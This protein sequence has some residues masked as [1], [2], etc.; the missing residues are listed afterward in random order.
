MNYLD[1]IILLPVAYG[2]I[3]GFMRG[4]VRELTS[5]IAV[6][7]G[8]IAA[9]IWAPVFAA[10]ILTVL[11]APEWLG[12]SLAY[13]LLF[14]GVALLCKVVARIVQRFLK[15]ISLGWLDKLVGGIFG[16][17]KWALI[18]SVLLNLLIIPEQYVKII[19]DD[20]KASSK[21]YGPTLSVA[22]TSWEKMQTYLPDFQKI[23]QEGEE[24]LQD[25][26]E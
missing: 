13:L 26:E 17:L 19:K 11:N 18:V 3:R 14:V 9:K 6:I 21:L 25:D 22:S 16:G 8:I 2:I 7:A 1:I 10:K 20:A 24:L 23:R 4:F 5:I 15:A 12:Q